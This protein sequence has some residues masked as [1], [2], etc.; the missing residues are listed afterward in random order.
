MNDKRGRVFCERPS[1][2]QA[3]GDGWGMNKGWP[4]EARQRDI[5]TLAWPIASAMLGETLMGLVDTKLVGGLGPQALA[6]VGVANALFHLCFI[7]LLGLMR[8]VKVCTAHA[9]GAG[10]GQ[11]GPR[12]AAAGAGLGL[13]AGAVLGALFY[14]AAPLLQAVHIGPDLRAPA[15]AFLTVRAWGLPAACALAALIEHRQGIGDGRVPMWVGLFG[16]LLNAPLAYALI[17]GHAGLPA[18]GVAGAALATSLTEW[19]QLAVMAALLWRQMRPPAGRGVAA[20]GGGRDSPALPRLAWGAA[21]RE[22]LQVGLPTA[23]HFGCEMLAFATFTAILGSMPAEDIAAHQIASAI[24]RFNYLFGAA[25]G[26]AACILVGRA[27]GAGSLPAADA[28]VAA[29][30]R[31]AGL[32]MLISGVGI[33]LSGNALAHRFTANDEVARTA[34]TLLWLSALWQVMDAFNIVSRAALRGA[35]D[36]RVPAAIGITILWACV[37]TTVYLLG[38]VAGWGVVGGWCGFLI[39]TTLSAIFYASRWRRGAWRLAQRLANV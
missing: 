27:L 5:V 10:L 12:Y 25:I 19:L 18:M 26:E 39:A 23:V 4:L 32:F 11:H 38:R 36:V 28:A 2:R 3:L 20:L 30:I 16:N 9:Q 15:M 21:A 34:S 22:L 14:L 24:N 13:L 8:G 35:K 1:N 33:A 17:Y 29:A 37:P 31:V 7:T 6:G